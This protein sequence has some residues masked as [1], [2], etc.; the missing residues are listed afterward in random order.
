MGLDKCMEEMFAPYSHKKGELVSYLREHDGRSAGNLFLDVQYYFVM[1]E[2]GLLMPERTWVRVGRSPAP[3]EGYF[4]NEDFMLESKGRGDENMSLV[5]GE[6]GV[7]DPEVLLRGKYWS[8]Y[9]LNV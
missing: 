7:H 6:M 1:T 2:R 9:D 8:V 3:D 5:A 4:V